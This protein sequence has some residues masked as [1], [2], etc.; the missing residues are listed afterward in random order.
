[1]EDTGGVDFEGEST[2]GG[3]NLRRFCGVT[4]ADEEV[5]EDE[6]AAEAFAFD[7]ILRAM[8]SSLTRRMPVEF[9]P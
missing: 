7:P 4:G 8:D 5:A 1:V 3:L 2:A 9:T 6:A